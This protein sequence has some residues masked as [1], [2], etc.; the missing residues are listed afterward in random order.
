MEAKH[1]RDLVVEPTLKE[2]GFYSESAAELILGTIAHESKMGRYLKQIKGPAL[3]I[4]QMEPATHDDIWDNYLAFR[5]E[6]RDKVSAL[7]IP[8]VS[9]QEQLVVN[10]KYAVVMARIHYLR[11]P[12]PLPTADDLQ[13]LAE[14]WDT[15]YN[16]NPLKGFPHQFIDD[17]RR[18]VL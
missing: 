2:F 11:V 4:V 8:C 9:K 15:H 16:R 7:L 6:L 14:Y 1:L 12:E 3:G 5:P 17:Y 18:F 13:G 10:L